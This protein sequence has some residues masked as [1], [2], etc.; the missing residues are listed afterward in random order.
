MVDL[1]LHNACYD[2]MIVDDRWI[3]GRQLIGKLN[4]SGG[5]ARTRKLY[6]DQKR[7]PN[8]MKYLGD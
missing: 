5:N 8:S 3:S 1:G 2:Y 7:F 4:N 6:P